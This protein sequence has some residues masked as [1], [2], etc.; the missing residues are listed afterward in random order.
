MYLDI[1]ARLLNIK[2]LQNCCRITEV[3]WKTPSV[4]LF[5]GHLLQ[6]LK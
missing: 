1:P 4:S 2:L 6:G 3:L 5:T